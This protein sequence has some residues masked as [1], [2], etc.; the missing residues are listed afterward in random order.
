[1][2]DR[3]PLLRLL[4]YADL[5]TLKLLQTERLELSR[6]GRW[7]LIQRYP[8]ITSAHFSVKLVAT[9]RFELATPALWCCALTS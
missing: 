5:A 7:N 3:K 6:R 4:G 9:A 1:M 8:A 2:R